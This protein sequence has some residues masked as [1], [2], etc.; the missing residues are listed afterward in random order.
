M[1]GYQINQPFDWSKPRLAAYIKNSTGTF[2]D[3]S[4]RIMEMQVTLNASYAVD[5]FSLKLDNTAR[6]CSLNFAK[7]RE[8]KLYAT[9]NQVELEKCLVGRI[10][11]PQ[12]GISKDEGMTYEAQGKDYTAELQNRLAV[13][14]YKKGTFSAGND[15]FIGEI[16]RDLFAKYATNIDA[17]DVPDTTTTAIKTFIRMSLFDATKFLADLINY[18]FYVNQ[19]RKLIF[20]PIPAELLIAETFAGSSGDPADWTENSGTWALDN[21]TYLQSNASGTH[22][23]YEDATAFT[24][25]VSDF[26]MKIESGTRAGANMRLDTGTGNSYYVALDL[27]E[28]LVKLYRSTNWGASLEELGIGVPATALA[29]ETE[30]HVRIYCRADGDEVLFHIFIDDMLYPVLSFRDDA[31]FCT[32]GQFGFTTE[33]ASA[34]FSDL[35]AANAYLIIEEG[36]NAT[37]IKIKEQLSRQKNNIYEE[38]GYEKFPEQ[39][40]TTPSGSTDEIA[41][42]Y[43]PSETRVYIN[44]VGYVKGGIKGIDDDDAS[45]V[46]LVD[47][48][49]KKLY[50]RSGNW[51]AQETTIDYN[52]NVP[53]IANVQDA[54]SFSTGIRDFVQTD[55][56]LN[57]QDMVEAQAAALLVKLKDAPK[58]GISTIVAACWLVQPGNY[59][60]VK[61]PSNELDD[62]T[63]MKAMSI[64]INFSKSEGLTYDFVLDNEDASLPLLLNSLENRIAKLERRDVAQALIRTEN[65]SDSV[66][67]QDVLTGESNDISAAFKIGMYAKLG[68]NRKLGNASG[69]WSAAF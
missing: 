47:Y 25:L 40:V 7:G 43:Q 16:V 49:A 51:P 57:T 58:T 9:F 69:G 56:L 26:N 36:F 46:F 45:V 13:E 33:D 68:H 14:I 53:L 15:P 24:D 11:D 37:S 6:Y 19:N 67:V 23:S 59:V 55:K 22:T 27:V 62:Y 20:E 12:T 21:N 63:L 52:R 10:E 48:Y 39:E 44:T 5:T 4:N 61:S 65:I 64:T 32:S 28:N 66:S 1:G 18:R 60:L 38:G 2:V 34:R 17:S 42:L 41:L 3:V 30:Y 50:Y 54:T 31:A 35:T 8:V 29:T